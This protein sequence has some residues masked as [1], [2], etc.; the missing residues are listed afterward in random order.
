LI[1]NIHNEK[2]LGID[3][4][5]RVT[6]YGIVRDDSGTLKALEFGAIKTSS[7]LPLSERLFEIVETLEEIA[8]QHKPACASVERIFTAVNMKTALLLGHARGAI[9]TA[10]HRNNIPVFEYS[11]LEIKRATVGYGRAQKNQVAEM[12]R[13]L[14]GLQEVPKPYDAADALAAA[15]CH[16]HS[17]REPDYGSSE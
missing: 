6:G 11:A 5:L 13:V 15:I 12:C 16:L 1:Y 4:G 17:R 9:L 10:L 14:L 2:V 3:P 8:V 7:R